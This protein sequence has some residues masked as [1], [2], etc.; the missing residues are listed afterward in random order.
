MEHVRARREEDAPVILPSAGV[1]GMVFHDNPGAGADYPGTGTV[2]DPALIDPPPVEVRSNLAETEV[3]LGKGS[4]V[5]G[6]G[7]HKVGT[8]DE[9]FAGDR[10][11]ID[12]F[13][14]WA[15]FL[16]KHDVRIPIAWVAEVD[17]ERVRLNVTADEAE[18]RAWAE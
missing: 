14:V 4:N 18:R 2:F 6:A 13:L 12:A 5:V 7:G 17:D 9:V 16:F 8:V 15:G 3:M 1:G 11:G 10:D